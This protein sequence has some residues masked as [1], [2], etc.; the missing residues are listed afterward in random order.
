MTVI[1]KV[2][3]MF[4][5]RKAAAAASYAGLVKAIAGGKPLPDNAV[6]LC[7]G[8]GRSV[9]DLERDADT[10]A[11]RIEADQQLQQAENL[12]KK[13]AAAAAEATARYRELQE[14]EAR[15]KLELDAARQ[16][17]RAADET[18]RSLDRQ[19]SMLVERATRTLVTTSDPAIDAK[20]Q[21]LDYERGRLLAANNDSPRMVAQCHQM[22][23][24]QKSTRQQEIADMLRNNSEHMN[25]IA[26]EIRQLESARLK[27]ESICLD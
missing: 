12:V 27:P 10:L 7:I 20:I 19:R 2:R 24:P 11:S 23:E 8:F 25:A 26:E 17:Y 15:H 3:E 16:A 6:D 13:E 22:P 5:G 18:S 14:L 21:Q 1:G 9:S 4:A